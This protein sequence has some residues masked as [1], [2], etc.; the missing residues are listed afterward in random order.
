MKSGVWKVIGMNIRA[1][2]RQALS[3][4]N[5]GAFIEER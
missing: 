2:L 3:G 5:A 4:L 1:E